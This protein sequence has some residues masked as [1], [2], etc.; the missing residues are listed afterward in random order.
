MANLFV[1]NSVRRFDEEDVDEEH[2]HS[3]NEV[4]GEKRACIAACN[5][6]M[7]WL[8]RRRKGQ[9]ASLID[10]LYV[11]SSPEGFL[12]RQ[13]TLDLVWHFYEVVEY[14]NKPENLDQDLDHLP[15]VPI[16]VTGG[17]VWCD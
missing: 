13:T 2:W 6:L 14:L 16:A 1:Y 17:R 12:H 10:A 8:I 4:E 5:L 9:V 11:L 7:H 3:R 15:K